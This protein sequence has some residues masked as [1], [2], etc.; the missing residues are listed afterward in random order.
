[1]DPLE[2]TNMATTVPR[3]G[4]NTTTGWKDCVA[5]SFGDGL[6]SS[7]LEQNGTVAS[8]VEQKKEVCFQ[9][10]TR[11]GYTKLQ[12][13]THTHAPPPPSPERHTRP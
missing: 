2:Q 5:V 9:V 8:V 4:Q 12:T 11:T 7:E 3:T 10:L 1:M 6:L 13:H